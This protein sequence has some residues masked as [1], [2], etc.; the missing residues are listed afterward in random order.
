MQQK[1][2][3][4]YLKQCHSIHQ[5]SHNLRIFL[6][7]N[8]WFIKT[9][10]DPRRDISNRLPEDAKAATLTTMP[11]MLKPEML[12]KTESTPGHFRLQ[13]TLMCFQ[14]RSLKGKAFHSETSLP[15]RHSSL[16]DYS[17][18]STIGLREDW[19]RKTASKTHVSSGTA[20]AY[21]WPRHHTFKEIWKGF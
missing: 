1:S 14:I 11:G 10:G 18:P 17:T 8:F 6:T 9:K 12:H 5:Y 15:D 21:K 3:I 2:R 16:C 19:E 13:F 4:L 7:G 20:L